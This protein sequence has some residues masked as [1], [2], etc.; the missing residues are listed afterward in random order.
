MRPHLRRGRY[1]IIHRIARTANKA[2]KDSTVGN[3]LANAGEHQS[4]QRAKKERNREGERAA[5]DGVLEYRSLN[6]GSFVFWHSMNDQFMI[7]LRVSSHR[8]HPSEPM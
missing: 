7:R 4:V 6:H 8:Y 2:I 1:Y 3:L 5:L